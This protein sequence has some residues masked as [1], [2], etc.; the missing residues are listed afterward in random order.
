MAWK[1][2]FVN[3]GLF[4][5]TPEGNTTVP[6]DNARQAGNVWTSGNALFGNYSSSE[7]FDPTFYGWNNATGKSFADKLSGLL[8]AHQGDGPQTD[9]ILA[10]FTVKNPQGAQ[11]YKQ[12]LVVYGTYYADTTA[13]VEKPGEPWIF[14]DYFYCEIAITRISRRV[15]ATPTSV[16]TVTDLEVS[17]VNVNFNKVI[18]GDISLENLYYFLDKGIFCCGNTHYQNKYYFSVGFYLDNTREYYDSTDLSWKDDHSVTFSGIGLDVDYLE[19]QFGG[20]FEPEVTDDPNEEP[21]EPGGGESG[22]GGGEDGSHE[23][24]YDPIPV[25]P[26][27]DLGPCDAGFIYM[28]RMSAA[29]MHLFAHDLLNPTWWAAI[30]AFFANPMEFICGVML[31]PFS[32]DSSVNVIPKFGNTTMESAYP[33]VS[34]EYKIISCGSL[35][36]SKYYDSCF[37]QNPYTSIKIWLPYLGYRDLDVDEVMGKDV[38]VEYHCDCLT[39]DCVVFLSSRGSYNG[40]QVTRVFAQYNGNCGVRVPFGSQS[41]DA[42][43]AASIQ[44]LGG[45]VGTVAGGIAAPAASAAGALEAGQIASTVAGASMIAAAAN[46]VSSERSG[47]AGATAG[48]MSIQYPYIL[49]TVP[50]QSRPGNYRELEGYPSNIAG[51]L[52]KFSGYVAIETINLNGIQATRE[53]LNEIDS[54]LRQGVYI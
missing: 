20:S 43:V 38:Y 54:L 4:N 30:K 12:E 23:G 40:R 17:T 44:L 26:L 32:P 18:E 8:R 24:K 51:P 37:D 5:N 11:F 48:Y 49:K 47:T 22:E 19:E 35:Y 9:V 33:L 3:T 27:P 31:V 13:H 50:R 28:L 10:A 52:T 46:K 34:N 25:P 29:Q 39:G 16:P 21:D 41:Y 36:I 2:S 6:F 1:P 15:Y 42:A 53:E 45:A 14:L 7:T